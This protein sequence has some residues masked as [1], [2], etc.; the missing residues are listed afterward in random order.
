LTLVTQTY[1]ADHQPAHNVNEQRP[2][3]MSIYRPTPPGAH[4][5]AIMLPASSYK[6]DATVPTPAI[7]PPNTPSAPSLAQGQGGGLVVNW[8]APASDATHGAAAAY[9]LQF[10]PSGANTWTF[11]SSVSSP[12]ALTDLAPATAFDVQI[13][14]TNSAGP[15]TWS[16]ISTLT[17]AGAVPGTPAAPALTQGPGVGLTVS[18]T[19]PAADGTHG[20]AT[21]FNLEWSPAG[22]NA[23]TPVT[24]V[25]SPYALTGLASGTSY[26]VRVQAVNA[27]GTGA[28]SAAATLATTSGPNAPNAPAITSVAPMPDGTTSKLVV[29]WTAPAADGTHD[30]ATGYNLRYSP[31]GAGSW[32]TVSNVTSPCT[33]TGLSGAE[34]V[35]VEVQAVNAAANPGAWSPVKTGTTW[36]AAVAQGV[37]TAAATQ[38]HG[39]GVAPNGGV[40]IV[41]TPAPTAVSGAAFAWSTSNTDVPNTGLVAASADGQTNGWGQWF[42]APAT[43]GTYYLWMLAQDAGGATVGALVSNAITVT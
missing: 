12:Y 34:A 24:S 37:W 42:N 6:L 1:G 7:Q 38:A 33:I 26:D 22:Q 4:A 25:T 5:R 19:A 16:A 27:A 11:L 43:A 18:W 2:Q 14:A 23:W 40:Q 13:Q 3:D 30:P 15:S 8:T 39:T 36:G 10:S 32:T 31:A 21:S 35:D 9:N 41:A 20:A 28:W 29:S 17:T